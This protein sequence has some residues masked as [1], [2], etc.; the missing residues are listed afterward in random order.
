MPLR[1]S[2]NWCSNIHL[3]DT[4][5]TTSNFTMGIHCQCHDLRTPFCA[6]YFVC[7]LHISFTLYRIYLKLWPCFRLPE[8]MTYLWPS[9]K[10]LWLR[11]MS[12]SP[13]EFEPRFI[14]SWEEVSRLT[15]GR[16]MVPPRYLIV[17][18]RGHIS[19]IYLLFFLICNDYQKW[20][21]DTSWVCKV[22]CITV[23][24]L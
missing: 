11:T 12:P 22:S 14:I 13:H 5:C 3:S 10:S 1:D 16:S 15:W 18:I 17:P 21:V 23:R 19:G 20:S 4:I 9:V 7:L 8:P 24:S 2:L 6:F